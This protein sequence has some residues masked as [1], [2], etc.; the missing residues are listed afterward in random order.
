MLTSNVISEA[1]SDKGF[2]SIPRACHRRSARRWLV[3][4]HTS[5]RVG[6]HLRRLQVGEHEHFPLQGECC[7]MG[8]GDHPQQRLRVLGIGLQDVF[9]NAVVENE[10]DC[11]PALF[12]SLLL[13]P[14]RLDVRDLPHL[15]V[16]L[17]LLRLPI[18][19]ICHYRAPLDLGAASAVSPAR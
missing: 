18:I 16:A 1:L 4:A 19:L 13:R 9:L 14:G 8:W 5:L 7:V 6:L 10:L 17:Q 11:E 3:Q 15:V 2:G 12:T